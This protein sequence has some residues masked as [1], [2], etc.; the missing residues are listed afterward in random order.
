MHRLPPLRS[1]RS[2]LLCGLLPA[3]LPLHAARADEPSP[4]AN[5]PAAAA[6]AS[7][8][9]SWG[10]GLG[11][12]YQ[13]QVY[14]D[15]DDRV[16]ALPLVSYENRWVRFN[17]PSVDLKLL[18]AGPVDLALRV[19]Y[20]MSGYEADDS[21]A[22]AGMEDRKS[23]LWA[24]A[25]LRWRG[26]LGEL[27]LEASGDASGN[28]KG[29]QARLSLAKD[30]RLGRLGLTPRVAVTWLDAKYVDFYYGVRAAEALATRAAYTGRATANTELG[31]RAG[32]GLAPNQLMFVDLSVMQLGQAIQDSPIVDASTA[33]GARLGYLYRF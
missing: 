14:R 27:G 16:L 11:V 17:V 3:L 30:F 24:G 21:P 26:G 23:G 1:T 5:T 6:P 32:Y 18:P 15:A 29:A 2:L 10:L 33:A 8:P 25:A 13:Q 4:P 19:R 28:S 31:L 9:S 12:I 7:P 22:L 20:D